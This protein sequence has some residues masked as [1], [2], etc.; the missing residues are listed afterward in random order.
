M[1]GRGKEEMEGRGKEG[2]GKEERGK[3]GKGRKG[4]G[5]GRWVDVLAHQI[6]L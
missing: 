5:R 6:T 1:E 2:R 4:R 3:G